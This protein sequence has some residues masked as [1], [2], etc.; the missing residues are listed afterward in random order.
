MAVFVTGAGARLAGGI[1]ARR[2]LGRRDDEPSMAPTALALLGGLGAGLFVLLLLV[3][4]GVNQPCGQTPA[5]SEWIGPGSL[6]GV[7]GTGLT[8]QELSL[9]RSRSPHRGSTLRAGSYLS[10]SYG[11][12]WNA[13]QG[14]G[15]TSGGI[16]LHDPSSGEN[17][18][19]YVLAVDPALI[20]HGTLVYVWPNPFGWRGPFV[21]ADTG[22]AIVDRHID[23]YDWRGRDYQLR[24]N[25]D[26]R[27]SSRP[28]VDGGPDVTQPEPAA[29]N[30]GQGGLLRPVAGPIT[31]PFGENRG[32]H[33][34]AGVD[35]GAPHGTPIR[36]AAGGTVVFQGVMAG[37]GNF[38]CIR[39]TQMLTTCYAHQARFARNLRQRMS[40]TAGDIIGYV[41]STGH[42]HGPHLH[43]EVRKGPG[44]GAPP[45]D[46]MPYLGESAAP[47][48]APS[49]DGPE[50]ATC[51][52]QAAASAPLDLHAGYVGE[53]AGVRAR[54]RADGKVLIPRNAPERVR[55]ILMAGNLI[56]GR[57]HMYGG[58]HGVP[59]E[60]AWKTTSKHGGRFDCS[61]SVS[62]LLWS[63][64]L[65]HDEYARS[66]AVLETFGRAGRGRWI[67][68][69]ANRGHVFM[70]VAGIRWDTHP[71][72]ADDG[73]DRGPAWYQ[74]PRPSGGF[75]TRHPPG[76]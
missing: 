23:I 7:A 28:I 63:A 1:A 32:D 64:G 6:S 70:E 56:A 4:T 36:A 53:T 5:P 27:I 37:Y 16:P 20:S 38:T 75:V 62:F 51:G 59:L 57:R 21:A 22:G 47:S 26:V 60:E 55:R 45:A 46:P 12:P 74:A 29:P 35:M 73:P 44:F 8:A 19:A 41:G 68:I 58:G 72:S 24:W 33:L 61:S 48:D 2:G 76:G 50:A 11:P 3:V 39:H 65:I 18:R 66:S 31:A 13:M 43:F 52:G 10:T 71:M 9:L 69:E 17:R 14:Y 30:A 15:V 34:H 40:V 67:T 54:I 25:H 42:S 49:A